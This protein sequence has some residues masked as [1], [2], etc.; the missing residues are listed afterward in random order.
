MRV[1][2]R[3][4]APALSAIALAVAAQS[5]TAQAP[6]VFSLEGESFHALRV[7]EGDVGT[8][9]TDAYCGS[10]TATRST[11]KYT[12]TGLADGPYFGTYWEQGA[13]TIGRRDLNGRPII[14]FN[15]RFTIDSWL[16]RVTGTKRLAPTSEGFG[17]MSQW[18]WNRE[19]PVRGARDLHR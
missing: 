4:A 13:A 17:E 8:I 15:A 7:A 18:A 10:L 2:K 16:G 11:I 6:P 14:G 19:P 5:A 1:S 12:T 3:W 9:R